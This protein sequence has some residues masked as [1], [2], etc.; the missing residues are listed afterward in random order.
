MGKRMRLAG[1]VATVCFL[2]LV[3]FPVAAQDGWMV[4]LYNPPDG[5]MLKI[6]ENG[7]VLDQLT[8]P[9]PQGFDRY[10]SRIAVGRNGTPFAYVVFN[11]T[12]FQGALVVAERDQV[13]ASFN[14]PVTIADST[15]FI[16]DAS[17]F[18]DDNSAVALGYSL[19]GG[20]WA[21]LVLD[22]PTKAVSATLRYDAPLV[23]ALGVPGGVGLTPVVRR[24][25]RR[26]VSFNLVQSG[27]EGAASYDSYDWNLDTGALTLNPV[28]PSLDSD[29]FAANGEMI[30][31]LPEDRKSVV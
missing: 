19:E 29:T 27:T 28:F 22:I 5:T 25:S 30:M 9:L 21:L 1:V 15:E 11:E 8:L 7:A 4:W 6:G 10:P 31:S 26:T 13:L 14:L 20:G 23:S 2:L 24:F 12:T 3:I 17:I 16:A 18:N